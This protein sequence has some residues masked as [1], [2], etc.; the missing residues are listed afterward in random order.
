MSSL[1]KEIL[2]IAEQVYICELSIEYTKS[3]INWCTNRLND[4]K[5][6]RNSR[7]FIEACEYV[8]NLENSIS[9]Y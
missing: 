4:Y 8:I 7:E 2:D 1:V 6:D 3:W 9:Y 5:G